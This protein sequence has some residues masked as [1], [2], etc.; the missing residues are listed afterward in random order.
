MN[1]DL[2]INII[3]EKLNLHL[4]P[5]NNNII[6]ILIR[7]H[8]RMLIFGIINNIYF[9]MTYGIGKKHYLILYERNIKLYF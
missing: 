9:Y 5:K 1:A 2:E 4:L 7:Y 8:F 6:L 3:M